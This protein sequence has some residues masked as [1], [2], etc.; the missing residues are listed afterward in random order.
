[1]EKKIII[2]VSSLVTFGFAI[3]TRRCYRRYKEHEK[4]LNF[5]KSKQIAY[6]VAEANE[7]LKEKPN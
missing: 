4:I 7:I 2:L 5:A 1:M 6:T 3:I